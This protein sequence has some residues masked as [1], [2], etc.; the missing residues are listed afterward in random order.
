MAYFLVLQL[1]SIS[2][3]INSTLCDLVSLDHLQNCHKDKMVGH[4]EKQLRKKSH[5]F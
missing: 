3:F 1:R 5:V 4:K 2:L